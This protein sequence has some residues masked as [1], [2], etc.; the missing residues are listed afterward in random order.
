VKIKS[1][2]DFFSGL[3][4]LVVGIAFAVGAT[5]YTV[6]TGARMGPGYFPLI[7]GVLMSILGTA[8]CISGLTKGPE[9]GDK[10]GKWAWKQV[11]F[12]LAANFAFGILLVGVPAVGIPQFGL[13]IA[14]YALVFIASLAGHSFNFKET[15]ILA[16][17]LAVGSYFAFVWAL[18]LQFPVWPSFIAG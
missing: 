12:I 2:K 11:C 8:I 17:V 3:M 13:I 14:I 6:G 10:I 5:N 16:T 1:Q 15:A 4:F 9:G 18:N 7:L